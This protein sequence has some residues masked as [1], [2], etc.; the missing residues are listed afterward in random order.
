MTSLRA[1]PFVL[2]A[3]WHKTYWPNRILTHFTPCDFIKLKPTK[4]TSRRV[5]GG[6]REAKSFLFLI[7]KRRVRVYNVLKAWKQHNMKLKRGEGGQEENEKLRQGKCARMHG[8]A[9]AALVL[10]FQ[11]GLDSSSILLAANFVGFCESRHQTEQERMLSSRKSSQITEARC[12]CM[13]GESFKTNHIQSHHLRACLLVRKFP[14]SFHGKLR[15]T[16]KLQIAFHPFIYFRNVR[17]DTK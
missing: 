13:E 6:Q 8:K 7:I 4:K 14:R 1:W 12:C 16:I 2:C 5:K 3:W 11:A 10:L 17:H 15:A 9:P